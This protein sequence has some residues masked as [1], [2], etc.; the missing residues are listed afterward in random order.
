MEVHG[1]IDEKENCREQEEAIMYLN[2]ILLAP[3]PGGGLTLY[4]L[5]DRGEIITTLMAADY[6]EDEDDKEADE[7]RK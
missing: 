3:A 6:V 2:P 4:R 1:I 5:N 7:Q